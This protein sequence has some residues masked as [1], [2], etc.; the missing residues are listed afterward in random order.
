MTDN[1]KALMAESE[2]NNSFDIRSVSDTLKMTLE[3]SFS[4]LYRLQRNVIRFKEFFY[5][6]SQSSGK[7]PEIPFGDLFLDDKLNVC[8]KIDADLVK[9]TAR[10]AFRISPLYNTEFTLED[11][12]N[13]PDIFERTI[14]LSIDRRYLFNYKIRM[15]NGSIRIILPYKMAYL[16]T[17]DNAIIDHKISVILVDNEYYKRI[18][19][20][21]GALSNLSGGTTDV[22]LTPKYVGLSNFRTDGLYFGFIEFPSDNETSSLFSIGTVR[23]DGNLFIDFPERIKEAIQQT[24]EEFTITLVFMKDLK[25]HVMTI[26]DP[27]MAS[28]HPVTS[29]LSSQIMVIEREDCVPYNMPIPTENMLVIKRIADGGTYNGEYETFEGAGT[30]IHYPNMYT[31]VDPN[32]KEGDMYRVFYFYKLGYDLHYTPKF[33]FYYRYLKRRMNKQT[34]EEA[35]NKVYLQDIT[36]MTVNDRDAFCGTFRKLYGYKPFDYEYDTIDFVKKHMDE[37]TPYEYRVERM[38]EFIADDTKALKDYVKRQNHISDSYYLFVSKIDLTRRVRNDTTGELQ[39]TI[40]FDEPRYL[41]IFQNDDFVKLNMRIWVDGLLCMDV[42]QENE[43][44]FDYIYIP[45]TMIKDDSYIEIEVYDSFSF[46]SEVYFPDME[47]M[48]EIVVVNNSNLIPTLSDLIF[49]DRDD[50]EIQYDLDSFEVFRVRQDLDLTT[51]DSTEGKRKVDY[52]T[53]DIIK[54]KPRSELVLH[55]FIT[56][57]IRKNSYYTLYEYDRTRYPIISLEDYYFKNDPLYYRI[58]LNGRLMSTA[59]YLVKDNFDDF[60]IQILFDVNKGDRLSLDITPFQNELIYFTETIP[61]DAII[62]LTDVIDK[63]FDIRFYD[64]FLNGRKLNETNVFAISDTIIKLININSIYHLEI[65]QKE[66][67]EEYF[68]WTK[69]TIQYYFRIE[70][71]FDEDFVTDEDKEEI[72]EDIIDETIDDITKENGDD[73]EEDGPIIDKKPNTNDEDKNCDD[74]IEYDEE[75]RNKIF[76]YEELL[77]K[78]LGDPMTTQFNKDY[79]KEEYPETTGTYLIEDSEIAQRLNAGFANAYEL[80]DRIKMPTDILYFDP[81]INIETATEVYF[82]GD[83]DAICEELEAAEKGE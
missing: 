42:I 52:T 59:M 83:Y 53:M 39:K 50:P 7:Y 80:I 19:T 38:H 3:N 75:L 12:E 74:E 18:K 35:V 77:P 73:P 21:K 61:E 63:P 26:G 34:L 22:V 14:L 24:S 78:R 11:I 71:L 57:A 79:I 49:I 43:Y 40:K 81:D 56:V 25:E 30:E 15:E 13:N 70:D 62:D 67:D 58:F 60:R 27:I 5:P 48:Q 16:Y 28:T 46:S 76:Y 44:G 47:T 69:N 4:Y 55:R 2:I 10:E 23:E 17:T 72:I 29:E 68:G 33:S 20:Q 36:D 41:F 8:L 51:F 6:H 1:L 54:I 66:R 31:I 64:V 32:M 82:L 9:Q 45:C 65:Y 37:K